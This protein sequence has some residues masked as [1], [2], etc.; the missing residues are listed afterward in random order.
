MEESV[1]FLFEKTRVKPGT[2]LIETV[3]SGDSLY[4]CMQINREVFIFLSFNTAE[5]DAVGYLHIPT[6]IA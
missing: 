5:T 2:L 6:Y 3:L 1:L 4:Y